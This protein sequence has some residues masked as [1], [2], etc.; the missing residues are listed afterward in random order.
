MTADGIDRI[1]PT[2]RPPGWAAM[3]QRWSR[4]LFLHWPVPAEEVRPL[5]PRGLELDTYAGQGWVGLVPFLVTGVRPVFLP[6]IPFVS[7]FVEVNVR[8]Y[9][10]HRG[11]DPGVWFFSLDASSHLAVRVAR[12]L[13][14]LEYRFAEMAADVRGGR[15]HFRSRRIGPGPRPGTCVVEYE[16]RGAPAAAVPGTVDH[17]LLERYVLYASDGRRLYR[18]RVH[19][20]PYPMQEA[21]VEG[22]AEDLVAAAGLVRPPREPLVHYASGVDVEVFAIAPLD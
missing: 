16:P 15:V 21:T 22:L 19:H 17:F 9:V 20:A 14:H 4:L 7:R 12:A 1:A 3:R 10:H 18:G 8:T 2:T 11:R 6:P 5:L 13:F